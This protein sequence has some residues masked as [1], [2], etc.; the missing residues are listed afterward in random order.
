MK[1]I[2]LSA[3]VL[4]LNTALFAQTKWTADKVHSTVKFSVSHLVISEVE[5]QFK[6]FEGMI[7]SKSADF[8]NSAITFNIDVKSI[9]T[10]NSDRDKHLLG[11]DFFDAD[12]Y[13]QMAFKST[14][15][16]KLSGNKYLLTG[17]LTLHGVT[18]PVKFNVT[19]GG[20]A[21]DGYG[22]T[23]AGFKASTVI[24]RFDYNLKWNALTEAGGATVGKDV[25]IELKLEFAQQKS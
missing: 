24:N 23:K 20:T 22:N 13:P 14:S 9:D 25:T 17:N 16:K 21:K 7:A 8:N 2:I 6:N 1:K 5:G 15:F 18:K 4:L 12:K 3:A 19:Y 10:E 11:P